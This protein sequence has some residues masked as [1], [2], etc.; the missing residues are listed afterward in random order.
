MAAKI[1]TIV[2]ARL[3]AGSVVISLPAIVRD[4]VEIK[5][6]DRVSVE[7]SSDGGSLEIRKE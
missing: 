7:V 5:P 2:K 4:A 3:V 1:R 6:G